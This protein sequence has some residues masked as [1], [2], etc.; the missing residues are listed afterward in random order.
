M[1]FIDVPLGDA[2]EGRPVP[3][4]EYDLRVISAERELS[5]AAKDRG[6]EDPNMTHVMVV[7]EDGEYPNAL[8]MHEYLLDV[9]ENDDESIKN[10]RGLNIARLLQVFNV[11]YE[12]NGYDSDDLV[13][14]TGRCL[15]I[16]IPAE[17][18]YDEKNELRLPRL[19]S[20]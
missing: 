17:G 9:S 5:K 4:G 20:E 16:L 13:A 12:D 8:P 11:A 18:Q 10:M 3:E 2:K 15:V 14:A 1:P 19:K 6:E 7:I